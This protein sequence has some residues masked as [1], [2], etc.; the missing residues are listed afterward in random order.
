MKKRLERN[1][2]DYFIPLANFLEA[3][4]VLDLSHDVI[5]VIFENLVLESRGLFSFSIDVLSKL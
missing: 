4:S 3:I 2:S 5:A 1:F